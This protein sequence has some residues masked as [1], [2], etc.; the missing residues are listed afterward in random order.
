VGD[1]R[2]FQNFWFEKV[3]M[4]S[5]VTSCT[6]RAENCLVLDRMNLM[7]CRCPYGT[8]HMDMTS[9][10]FYHSLER[11]SGNVSYSLIKGEEVKC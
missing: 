9:R 8:V 11:T 7:C 10:Q 4:L 3:V 5:T 2:V 6:G 1:Q